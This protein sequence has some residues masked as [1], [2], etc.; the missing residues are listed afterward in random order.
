ML[1]PHSIQSLLHSISNDFVRR[2]GI[3]T[4]GIY[5]GIT[6]ANIVRAVVLSSRDLVL[7]FVVHSWTVFWKCA[8]MFVIEDFYFYWIHRFLHWKRIYKYVHKGTVAIWK[9]QERDTEELKM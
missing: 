9:A 8:V 5:Y 2:L 7:N 1:A 3:K 6:F 4:I